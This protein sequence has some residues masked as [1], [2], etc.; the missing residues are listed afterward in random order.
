MLRSSDNDFGAPEDFGSATE[1]KSSRTF[2]I[3]QVT[4]VIGPLGLVK[5]ERADHHQL[6]REFGD[7]AFDG[8]KSQRLVSFVSARSVAAITTGLA[9]C[10]G[11][12]GH[13]RTEQSAM[14]L[15]LRR[16]SLKTKKALHPVAIPR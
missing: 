3:K 7:P 8:A 13:G 15:S 5:L 2:D 10:F 14:L 11:E 9:N 4:S 16:F 12:A 6:Q 1:S